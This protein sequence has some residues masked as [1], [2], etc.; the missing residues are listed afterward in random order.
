[1]PRSDQLSYAPAGQAIVADIQ[2][3]TRQHDPAAA[4]LRGSRLPIRISR[5]GVLL[6]EQ[7]DGPKSS[8]P[9]LEG[10]WSYFATVT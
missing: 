9:V 6:A 7:W 3:S 1:M 10:D 2:H 5:Q 8:A 4:A